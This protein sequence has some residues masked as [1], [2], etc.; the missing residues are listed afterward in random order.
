[1]ERKDI[2]VHTLI[3]IAIVGSFPIINV[4]SQ[5]C[6][7]VLFG[8]GGPGTQTS[9]KIYDTFIVYNLPIILPLAILIYCLFKNLLN[10]K[11]N[12]AVLKFLMSIL[13][14]AAYVVMDSQDLIHK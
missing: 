13:S 4:L 7:I 14:I 6:L 11:V 1:M 3:L 12:A 9:L 10:S 8:G 2:I 5:L